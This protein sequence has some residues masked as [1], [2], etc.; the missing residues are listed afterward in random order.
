M[1]EFFNRFKG[2]QDLFEYAKVSCSGATD[3]TTIWN[4]KKIQIDLYTK[5]ISAINCIV[6][7]IDVVGMIVKC[8]YLLRIGIIIFYNV[9]Y[10]LKCG[11]PLVVSLLYRSLLYILNYA[12]YM[13]Y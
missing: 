8:L 12:L 10:Y 13:L 11:K 1:P 5:T 7:R 9:Y 4:I 3:A 6:H 2:R